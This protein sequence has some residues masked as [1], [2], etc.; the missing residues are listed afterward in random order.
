MDW[1]N[2]TTNSKPHTVVSN[3]Q[4]QNCIKDIPYGKRSV[5]FFK[6]NV[7]LMETLRDNHIRDQN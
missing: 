4:I 1:N 7:H 5:H 6:H 3:L 2:G